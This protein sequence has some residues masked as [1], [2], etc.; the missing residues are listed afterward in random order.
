MSRR[1]DESMNLLSVVRDTALDPGYRRQSGQRP[2]RFRLLTLVALVIAGVLF[3]L[4]AAQTTRAEPQNAKE[5][6][7]LISRIEQVRGDQDRLRAELATLEAETQRLS[8]RLVSDPAIRLGLDSLEPVVGAAT[9]K[10]PG[11]V[12]VVDDAE[13]AKQVAGLVT[14]RDIRQLVNGLWQ[15]GA[16][17]I[18]IN[19]HRLS[20][21]TAIRGAGSAITVDYT[22]LL[23]P[24]TVEAIGNPKT[25]AASFAQTSGGSWWNSLRANYGLQYVLK[26]ADSLTLPADPGLGLTQASTNGEPK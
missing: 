3:A 17:A 11:V 8:E 26:N 21:R 15:A 12:I 25:L 23:R 22:S 18:A 9:V 20:T 14:D 24:Y 13:N 10:G 5:R 2:L 6:Q 7:E 16:E 19:G 4:S 1:P